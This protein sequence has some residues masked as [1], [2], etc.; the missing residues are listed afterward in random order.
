MRAMI[1]KKTHT[2]NAQGGLTIRRVALVIRSRTSSIV[3]L[4]IAILIFSF[5]NSI[6]VPVWAEIPDEAYQTLKG[7][8]FRGFVKGV[9]Y[10]GN[11]GVPV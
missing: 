9:L 7:R 6:S 3:K 10:A 11:K 8:E 1:G 2:H 4:L 5:V